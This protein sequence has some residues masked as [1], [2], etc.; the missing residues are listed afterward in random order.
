M[1]VEGIPLTRSRHG[2]VTL[3]SPSSPSLLHHSLVKHPDGGFTLVPQSERSSAAQS[4]LIASG[5]LVEMY[6]GWDADDEDTAAR[7]QAVKRKELWMQDQRTA[8]RFMRQSI[9]SRQAERQG[10]GGQQPIWPWELGLEDSDMWAE[11]WAVI[12]KEEQ[13][14]GEEEKGGETAEMEVQVD[15]DDV[16]SRLQGLSGGHFTVSLRPA[17]REDGRKRGQAEK[18]RL[19]RPR[20]QFRT[21]HVDAVD[22]DLHRHPDLYPAEASHPTVVF[23]SSDPNSFLPFNASQATR[24][25]PLINPNGRHLMDTYGDSLRHVNALLTVRYGKATRKAPAHM[26]HLID[27]RVMEEVQARWPSHYDATSSH[28]FRHPGDM[29]MAF[30]YAYYLMNE[31]APF[32]LDALWREQLDWDGDGRL[33]DRE[34][35]LMAYYIAGQRCR[36]EDVHDLHALLANAS[37]S[38]PPPHLPDAFDL[39]AV[40]ALPELV[41]ALRERVQAGKKY[42]TELS[43]LDDVEFY[44]LTDANA[45]RVAARLDELRA[46]RPKWICLNDEMNRSQAASHAATVEALREFYASYLPHPSPFENDPQQPNAVLH[47]DDWR[48]ARAEAAARR[49]TL[50]AALGLGGSLLLLLCCYHCLCAAPQSHPLSGRRG[51][52]WMPRRRAQSPHAHPRTSTIV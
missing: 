47:V 4:Y 41:E 46:K 15:L 11:A 6:G 10:R 21:Q 8:Q 30:T 52:G 1:V 23:T 37:A 48:R 18:E 31:P 35:R 7:I 38:L 34:V 13:G 27:R 19:S 22:E 26:P 51:M 40:R 3:R 17:S 43:A 20:H 28:R 45:T 44:M 42:K 32:D 2:G 5:Q 39:A 33:S 29:Q 50:M 24:L 49:R 9:A 14:R 12:D 16:V 25:T 36:D